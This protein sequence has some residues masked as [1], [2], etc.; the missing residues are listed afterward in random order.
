M[1]AAL[2]RGPPQFRKKK[3]THTH[4]SSHFDINSHLKTINLFFIALQ[5]N[6]YYVIS[7][8]IKNANCIKFIRN[9]FTHTSSVSQ[10]LVIFLE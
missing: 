6:F 1:E 10:L 7:Y 9:N 2:S 5:N 4:T 8:C 3:K